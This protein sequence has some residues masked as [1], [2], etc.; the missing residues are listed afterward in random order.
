MLLWFLEMLPEFAFSYLGL[1]VSV[2]TGMQSF[3]SSQAKE[4]T[5]SQGSGVCSSAAAGI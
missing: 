3:P 2:V 1:G 5:W 4:Q